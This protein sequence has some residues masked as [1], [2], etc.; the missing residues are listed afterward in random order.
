MSDDLWVVVPTAGRASMLGAIDSTGV[1]RE[2]TVVV[3]T[4][5]FANG[6]G[7]HELHDFGDVNIHRWWNRGIDYAVER[8]ALY[9]AVINDDIE[10]AEDALTTLVDAM[11]G[12]TIA[13]PGPRRRV[14]DPS[15]SVPMTLNG[16]CW[17]LDASTG[18]RAD[19]GYRWWYGDND[20]DWRA[21]R[22]H[23]GVVSVPVGF[24]HLT[25]NHLTAEREDL[26][27]LASLDLARWNRP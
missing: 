4:S 5:P 23:G 15:K 21:R 26:Q 16:A 14:T 1:P 6:Y 18:L 10:L 27:A 19:E 2:R 17:V 7:C 22:D 20:L 11:D 25:P 12:A 8:G 9:V 13:S 3:A 24:D